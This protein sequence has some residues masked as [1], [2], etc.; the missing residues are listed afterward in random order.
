MQCIAIKS[1]AVNCLA[2]RYGWAMALKTAQM[3]FRLR[4]DI[5]SWLEFIADREFRSLSQQ[6]ELFLASSIEDWKRANGFEGLAT[7]PTGSPPAT[8]K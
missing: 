7:P 5:R 2:L 6:T 8:E 3:T 4:S 1:I